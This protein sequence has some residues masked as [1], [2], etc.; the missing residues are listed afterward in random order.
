MTK[1]EKIREAVEKRMGDVINDRYH[2]GFRDGLHCAR[3][4]IEDILEEKE[5]LLD[6]FMTE[7]GMSI[8]NPLDVGY[9]LN[10][11]SIRSLHHATFDKYVLEDYVQING[12]LFLFIT[13][14]D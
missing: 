13:E 2:E 6:F 7:L 3:R 8:T 12:T 1:L 11:M 4:E 14:K 9:V 10:G 5:S